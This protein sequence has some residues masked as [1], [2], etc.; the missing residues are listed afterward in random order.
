[1]KKILT[2]AAAMFAALTSAYADDLAITPATLPVGM[3]GVPYNQTL[4][5]EGGDQT[6]YQW[7]EVHASWTTDACSYQVSANETPLWEGRKSSGNV[8]YALPVAFPF[9]ETG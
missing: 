6:S 5:V 7:R 4:F 3:E 9:A 8:E 2:L 1:M